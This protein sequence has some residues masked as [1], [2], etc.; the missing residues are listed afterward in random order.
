MSSPSAYVRT[1]MLRELKDLGITD[2]DESENHHI[3]FTYKGHKIDFTTSN[4][5][6]TFDDVTYRGNTALLDMLYKL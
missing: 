1:K 2:I 6:F 5:Y 4:S 3:K